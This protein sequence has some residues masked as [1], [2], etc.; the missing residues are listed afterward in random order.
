MRLNKFI[1]D[2]GF[3]S[4]READRLIEN[5]EV[6]VNGTKAVMG[7]Q[8]ADSDEVIINGKKIAPGNKEEK[9]IYAF[10]KPVGVV[11]TMAK[12]DEDSIFN[13]LKNFHIQKRI[14]P[15][16]RLDKE[17]C[18]L[19]LLTN[20][21]ELMNSILKTSNNHQK[22]YVVKVNKDITNDFIKK[23]SMGVEIIDGNTG[24]KV[25]TRKC[26]VKQNGKRTFTIILKQGLNRQI[27]RMC[28]AFGYEVLSL[29]RIRIMNINLSGM[30]EGEI[31]TLTKEENDRL[32]ELCQK[33]NEQ[34]MSENAGHGRNK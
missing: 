19:M 2:A 15:V 34:N 32:R 8:V 18:G 29:K 24:K 10:Y 6:F 27:R 21:G 30:K 5:G 1:S 7:V 13:F 33:K 17:S 4:R 28:G 11:S 25:I 16:G 23:M 3:C 14:Y 20:D 22:E 26:T 9:I 12:D 31:R